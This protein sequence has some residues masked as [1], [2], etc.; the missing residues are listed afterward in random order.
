MS[1]L[2]IGGQEWLLILIGILTIV[3]LGNYGRNTPLGYWGSVLLAMLGTPLVAF[4]VI[5]ILRNRKAI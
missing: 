3:A 2:F 4:I 5:F 1:L